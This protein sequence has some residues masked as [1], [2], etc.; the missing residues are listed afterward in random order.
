[1]SDIIEHGGYYARLCISVAMNQMMQSVYNLATNKIYH[2]GHTTASFAPQKFCI[3]IPKLI[4]SLIYSRLQLQQ[5]HDAEILHPSY[6]YE[7]IKV[8]FYKLVW[9]RNSAR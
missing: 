5:N 8:K 3:L 7:N 6:P 2:L 1:M 4:F 9:C